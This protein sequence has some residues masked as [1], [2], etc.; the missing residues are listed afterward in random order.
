MRSRRKAATVPS[1]TK[2]SRVKCLFCD[3]EGFRESDV[4]L[5]NEYC[6]YA[7]DEYSSE[8]HGVLPGSGIIVPRVHRRNPFELTPQEWAATGELLRRAGVL[9][10]ERWRPDGYTVGWNHGAAGGQL[11]EHVHLHVIPRFS[12]EPHAGHGLRW[13]IKQPDNR[14]PTPLLPG[15]GLADGPLT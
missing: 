10:Q 3:I 6:L 5:E 4:F 9:I 12:D 1:V 14:R 8:L 2:D 11:A 7:A 13:A 15:R